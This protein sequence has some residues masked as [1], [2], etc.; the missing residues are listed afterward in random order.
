MET[1]A[2]RARPAHPVRPAAKGGRSERALREASRQGPKTA[3]RGIVPRPASARGR[4]SR[5]ADGAE[6]L[7]GAAQQV[8]S[9]VQPRQGVPCGDT[10]LAHGLPRSERPFTQRRTAPGPACQ[11]FHRACQVRPAQG[12]SSTPQQSSS[13]ELR[14]DRPCRDRPARKW[15]NRRDDLTVEDGFPILCGSFH[16]ACQV[17]SV[18]GE[19]STPPNHAQRSSAGSLFVQQVCPLVG[20]SISACRFTHAP[21]GTPQHRR[22]ARKPRAY[23]C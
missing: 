20:S 7:P 13:L 9:A 2:N 19:P 1:R 23:C 16:R 18:Q 6:E 12:E 11:A 15:S 3:V 22:G 8:P 17:R 14:S 21:P 10:A 5:R 4:S